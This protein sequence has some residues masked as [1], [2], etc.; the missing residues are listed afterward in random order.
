MFCAKI[1]PAGIRASGTAR[2]PG[3]TRSVRGDLTWATEGRCFLWLKK[4]KKGGQNYRTKHAYFQLLITKYT[5][6]LFGY[7]KLA[8]I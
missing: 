2:I 5:H 8:Y 4:V 7:N 3:E 1:F 6:W